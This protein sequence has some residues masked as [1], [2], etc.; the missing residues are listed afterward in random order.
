VS[1]LFF[2]EI[3]AMVVVGGRITATT[4]ISAQGRP[5]FSEIAATVV[6]DES[7]THDT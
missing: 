2:V 7:M 1:L 3:A 6:V 4:A 5:I